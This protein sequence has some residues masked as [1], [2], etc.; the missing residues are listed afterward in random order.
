MYEFSQG[1]AL[2]EDISCLAADRMLV[3]VA[4]GGK[5]SAFARNKEVKY[6]F[7]HLYNEYIILLLFFLK[8]MI[9]IYLGHL[10]VMT[11]G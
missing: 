1:N 11:R 8:T 2:P 7:H 5:V 9:S 10:L 3:Y 6:P 4:I